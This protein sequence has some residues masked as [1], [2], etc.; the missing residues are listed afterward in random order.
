M[1]EPK[2]ESGGSGSQTVSVETNSESLIKYSEIV[3]IEF[4]FK[5][6]VTYKFKIRFLNLYDQT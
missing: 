3:V 4:E 2:A 1:P 6:I 5:L